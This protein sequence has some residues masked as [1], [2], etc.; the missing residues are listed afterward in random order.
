VEA[1]LTPR[2]YPE[3]FL[4]FFCAFP[5][6]LK[7]LGHE[8]PA[9]LREHASGDL[10]P[11]VQ[12]FTIGNIE[13]GTARAG[14]GVLRAV[15]YVL[16][17]REHE[18]PRAHRTRLYRSIYGTVEQPLAA[19]VRGR[20]RYRYHLGVRGRVLQHLYLVVRPRYYAPFVH[21]HGADWYFILLEGVAGLLQGLGHVKLVYFAHWHPYPSS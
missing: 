15:I 7:E 11:V 21:Y 3:G 16:H 2:T 5:L 1:Q 14:L 4:L 20:L 18:G 13:H 12:F 8:R 6:L 19:E 10:Y 9:F 17:A